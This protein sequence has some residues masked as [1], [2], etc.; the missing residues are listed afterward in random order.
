M[1]LAYFLAVLSLTLCG[2]V[3]TK[4][5]TPEGLTVERT[6][7]Y[8]DFTIRAARSADGTLMVEETQAGG[9]DAVQALLDLLRAGRP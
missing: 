9:Q 5:T 2:C 6:A 7:V 3:S 1:R 4:V 8:S